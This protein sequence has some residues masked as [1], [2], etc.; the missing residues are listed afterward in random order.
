[1]GAREVLRGRPKGGW[2]G[3]DPQRSFGKEGGIQREGAR[4]RLMP[5]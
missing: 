3:G 5:L 1:M 4:G 2:E